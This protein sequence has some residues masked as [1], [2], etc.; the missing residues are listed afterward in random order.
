MLALNV[1]DYFIG[2]VSSHLKNPATLKPSDNI[3]KQN[4]YPF[5]LICLKNRWVFLCNE[6]VKLE[7]C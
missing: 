2:Y 4:A 5:D 3:R 7:N 6:L 1:T